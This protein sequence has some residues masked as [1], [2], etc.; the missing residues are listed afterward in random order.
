MA[1]MHKLTRSDGF[2]PQYD[3]EPRHFVLDCCIKCCLLQP[4]GE[5]AIL[6][7]QPGIGGGR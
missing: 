6:F 2:P 4:P 5:I 1:S 7:H 3:L